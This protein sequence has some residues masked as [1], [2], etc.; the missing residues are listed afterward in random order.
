MDTLRYPA[1]NLKKSQIMSRGIMPSGPDSSQ[2]TTDA[3][4]TATQAG[5]ANT[6]DS[7]IGTGIVTL[8]PSVPGQLS[9]TGIPP[10][11]D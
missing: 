6:P 11:F 1:H 2:L 10:Q 5:D 9:P 3:I 8:F 7:A 4:A